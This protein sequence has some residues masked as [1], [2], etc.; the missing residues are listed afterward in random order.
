MSARLVSRP[1]H[2][3]YLLLIPDS[4]VHRQ[5][6][7]LKGIGRASLAFNQAPI[8]KKSHFPRA[9]QLAVLADGTVIL[10]G[11]LDG[12]LPMW[13]GICSRTSSVGGSLS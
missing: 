10:R 6:D 13:P 12:I 3:G 4:L 1:W 5:I 11:V 2:G 8:V 7:A 9:T